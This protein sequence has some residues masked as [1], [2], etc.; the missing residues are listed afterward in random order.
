MKMLV[1]YSSSG[2]N[3]GKVAEAIA[4]ELKCDCVRVT[5][6]G[7]LG[8]VDL[9]SY[10]LVFVGTGIHYGGPNED[11]VAYLKGVSLN[12]SGQFALFITWGGAGKTNQTV[13]AALKALLE[14][15]GQKVHSDAFSCYGGWNFLRRGHPNEQ[16]IKAAKE[17]ATKTANNT[18]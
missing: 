4:S 11:I 15:K 10:D 12:R 2:G 17:W 7:T 18:K 13:F 3:T 9:D 1:L 6:S 14:S 8:A 5:R 16:E